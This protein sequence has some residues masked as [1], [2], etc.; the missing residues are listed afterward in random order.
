MDAE[1]WLPISFTSGQKTAEQI[2]PQEV[3]TYVEDMPRFP[4]CEQLIESERAPCSNQ[5]MFKY[6]YESIL[7]PVEDR[8]LGNQGMV[9]VQFVVT[10]KG[11]IANAKVVRGV[12][13]GLNAEALRVV[14]GMNDLPQKWTPGRHEGKAVQVSYTLPLKFVLQENLSKKEEQNEKKPS[15]I[16]NINLPGAEGLK[17]D[18]GVRLYPNP[19]NIHLNVDVFEGAHTIR[20]FDIAGRLQ[21]THQIPGGNLE[22]KQ[23]IDISALSE[24]QYVLQVI[25]NDRTTTMNFG[26]TK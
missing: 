5:A 22:M 23:T 19:T 12:S 17:K 15:I 20:I 18:E 14:N 9:L 26:V 11:S 25:S 8:E 21:L 4:G 7:Y 3:F 13:P 2:L 1:M 6:I 24:G 10:E 16:E